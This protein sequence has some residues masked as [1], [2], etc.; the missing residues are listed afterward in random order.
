MMTQLGSKVCLV[1]GAGSGIGQA[2]T[3]MM[4]KAGA[5]VI[6]A[7]VDLDSAVKVEDAVTAAGFKADAMQLNVADD[8]A[9]QSAMEKILSDHGRLD[10]LVNNAGISLASSISE[11]TLD[12]WRKVMAVNLDG[13]FMGTRHAVANMDG[14][15]II[16]V[17]SVSGVTPAPGAAAYAASKAAVR[18]LSKVAALECA[19][20]K[21]GIRVNVV[22]PGGVK[23]P[24]WEKQEF[25]QELIREHG[26]TDEAF[27]AME[28]DMPSDQFFSAEH[29][30]K[31][32]LYLASDESSHLTGTE[33]VLDRGHSG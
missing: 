6:V 33:I 31:T 20:S 10:V 32:I 26:S 13:V 7:D 16:N 21:S 4:A 24:M 28:G 22:T 14:G 2:T 5:T 15:S 23:T 18:M 30:A 29:V 12:E 19:N 17:A 8:Q 11:C 27:A 9:W 3:G 25:F 1:T